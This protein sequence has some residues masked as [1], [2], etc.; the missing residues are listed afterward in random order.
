MNKIKNSKTIAKFTCIAILMLAAAIFTPM[1]AAA[2]TNQI[3]N[4]NRHKEVINARE[5]NQISKDR[6]EVVRNNL[7]SAR[8]FS[9]ESRVRFMNAKEQFNNAR[10]SDNSLALKGAT[11]DYLN[12][13]IE[14][15]ILHLESLIQR[16]EV[17]QNNGNV[18]FNASDIFQGYIA[19]LEVLKDDV[20]AAESIDEFQAIT[21]EIK[22]IWN[23]INLQSK[24]FLMWTVNNKVDEFLLRSDSISARIEDEIEEMESTGKETTKLREL[25]ADYNGE[26]ADAKL[27]HERANEQFETHEGF[28]DDGNLIGTIEA[29]RFL[30]ETNGHIK[31]TNH[32]L[33]KANSCLRRI[34]ADLKEHRIGLVT[35]GRTGSLEASGDGKATLSGNLDVEINA[36]SGVL[37]IIDY[38][39][40]AQINVTG[41]GTKEDLSGNTVKYSGFDGHATINGSGITVALNGTDIELTAEGTGSSLLCGIGT[42]TVWSENEQ[43][44]TEDWAP[45]TDSLD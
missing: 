8:Q 25:L 31:K 5:Q 21:K 16:A 13:T 34:F 20:A 37:V 10:T 1:V 22:E 2:E 29:R 44:I 7:Q 12:H 6:L 36:K 33:T 45:S 27:N 43:S 32:A 38:E 17:T 39:G 19:D 18:P 26:L 30:N 23:N 35:L 4:E 9:L 14:Y 15:T 41:N 3:H 42:Y 40:D 11:K 28:D 24:Y